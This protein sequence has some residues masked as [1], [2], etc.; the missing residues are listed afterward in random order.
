MIQLLSSPQPTLIVLGETYTG[1]SMLEVLD[2]MRSNPDQ[3]PTIDQ[4]DV[5]KYLRLVALWFQQPEIPTL[6]FK[7]CSE[8][9]VLPTKR[10]SDV[11]FDLTITRVHSVVSNQI[12]MFD[13]GV[14]LDVPVGYYVE[15]VPRSSMSKTGYMLANSVGV[16]DPGYLGTIKVPLVKIDQ[17]LPDIQLPCRIAQLILKPYVF[18]HSVLVDSL[19]PTTRGVGGFGSTNVTECDLSCNLI[20]NQANGLC[21]HAAQ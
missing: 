9:A 12:T 10:V 6:G 5:E 13:T 11:G 20:C 3:Y 14:A 7:L 4:S 15:M 18:A 8:Q 21:T 16:I 1:V 17:S 2:L 19:K